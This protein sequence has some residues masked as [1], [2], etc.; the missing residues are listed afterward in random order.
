MKKQNVILKGD[1]IV[2][3]GKEEF[4]EEFINFNDFKNKN[5]VINI[6]DEEINN[7]SFY[8]G[9]VLLKNSAVK[10]IIDNNLPHNEDILYDYKINKD[11]VFIYSI[12][13]GK[14][15]LP[16]IKKNKNF[17]IVPFQYLIMQFL[18]R[19]IHCKDKIASIIKYDNMYYLIIL[20][21]KILIENYINKNVEKILYEVKKYND[22]TYI[23]SNVKMENVDL[24][25]KIINIG[26]YLNEKLL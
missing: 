14:R 25:L 10:K 13:A 7:S 2:F 16:I 11:E 18:N 20:K 17:K 21:N 9:K 22:I 19:K 15:V 1:S 23:Y 8:I 12:R 6:L 4:I 26:D 3:N 24:E 5:L